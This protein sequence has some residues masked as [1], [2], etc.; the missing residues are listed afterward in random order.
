MLSVLAL[1]LVPAFAAGPV[2]R[3]PP[4][5]GVLLPT[6]LVRLV[7]EPVPNARGMSY[8]RTEDRQAIQL[9]LDEA[10]GVARVINSDGPS[11]IFEGQS[12]LEVQAAAAPKVQQDLETL[13]LRV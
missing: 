2:E 10:K 6:G 9:A 8:I 4:I 13:G 5:P 11:A 1:I 12:F 7:V 3:L